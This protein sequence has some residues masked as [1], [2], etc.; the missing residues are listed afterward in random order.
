MR[1]GPRVRARDFEE[2]RRVEETRKAKNSLKVISLEWSS[3]PI[4]CRNYF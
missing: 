4:F 3:S 2:I 1:K